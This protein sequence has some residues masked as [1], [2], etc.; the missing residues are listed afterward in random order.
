MKILP[1][2]LSDF[3]DVLAVNLASVPHV[4]IISHDELRWF[5]EYAAYLQVAIIDEKLAGFLVGLRPGTSYASP[6]YRWFCR[7]YDDFA[8]IDRVAVSEWARRRGVAETLYTRFA[9]SQPGAPV[10]TCEVNLR[11]PNAGSM[12]FH[13]RM[14]FQQVGSQETDGGDKEVALMEKKL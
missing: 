12:R 4:N 6:N 13:K 5:R 10:M 11:P 3:E 8:Y 7:H 9:E 2:E 1:I 14:G